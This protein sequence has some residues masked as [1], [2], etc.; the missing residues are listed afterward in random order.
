ME[1]ILDV[2]S[3]ALPGERNAL[4]PG[5][6]PRDGDRELSKNEEERKEERTEKTAKQEGDEF[7]TKGD[8]TLSRQAKRR[9][10]PNEARAEKRTGKGKKEEI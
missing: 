5:P 7:G 8:S 6:S 10:S 2:D 1:S 3:P 9:S 4:V